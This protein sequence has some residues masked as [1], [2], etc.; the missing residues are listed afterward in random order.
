MNNLLD[1]I[2]FRS[3]NLKYI[4]SGF[5][6]IKKNTEVDQIFAAIQSFSK[7]SEIRYVGG[8]VRKIINRETVD[9]IDLA[10]N[11]KPKEVCDALNKNKIKYYES[12]IEHGTITALINNIKF[13]ITSLRK[14]IDTDGRH[15]KV[16]F[17]DNWEE[18]ASRRDFTINSIYA[19]IEGNLFDPFDGKKD[20]E[21]GKVN[22]IGDVET[23]IKEDYLRI[24]RYVRFFLNYSKNKHDPK[25]IKIIKKNLTGVSRISAERL[26]DEFQKLLKSKGFLKITKDKDC[27]EII[28]LIFPQLKN[29]SIFKKLNNFAKKKF[30]RVDFIFLLSLLVIDGTDNVDYFIYKFNLSKKDKKR[31]LFL[32][33]FNSEKF[34]SKTFLEKN[35]NKIFYFHGKEALID[36]IHF[37]IFKSNKVD[38][39]LVRLIEIFK[40][41]EIP[42]MP[43]KANT[44]I[45]KYQLIEGKNLGKKLKIIEEVWVNNNFNISEKE[46]QKIVSN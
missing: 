17:S 6:D 32:N 8:C 21:N 24:L 28:N 40:K 30:S 23:R 31:L 16:E 35:L 27:V 25:I 42:V 41:K 39:K 1:K 20:L 34:T 2:F 3:Q 37:K 46:I 43:L 19:N 45:E 12:G 36:I 18:D 10:V 4:N 29:I 15:A 26:L 5:K 22:F 44:L 11:L 33:E 9:D 14:D 7:N 38:I 13:E